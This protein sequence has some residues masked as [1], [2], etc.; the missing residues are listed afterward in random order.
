MKKYVSAY[1]LCPFY[2]FEDREYHQVM[3]CEGVS[4]TTTIHLTFA[5]PSAMMAHKEA[6]CCGNYRECRIARMLFDKYKEERE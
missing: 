3:V 2:R 5:S 1:V 6:Y 4:D